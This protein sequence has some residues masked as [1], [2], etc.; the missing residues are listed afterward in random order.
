MSE[1]NLSQD[2][3]SL[4]N[5]TNATNVSFSESL[6]LDINNLNNKNIVII[7]KNLEQKIPDILSFLQNNSN[8]AVNKK[9][10]VKYL[11]NLFLS[12]KINSEVFLRKYSSEK[13]RLNLYQIIIEQYITYTNIN[14]SKN[15]ENDYRKE[16]FNLF[17]IL[18]SQ[19]TLNRESYHY[20]L[21]F[22]LKFINEKN[23]FPKIKKEE[24]EQNEEEFHLTAEHLTRILL[25]LQKFYQ[26]LD[27]SKMSLN[28]F[29][30]YGESES[31]ITIQ[32][33]NSIKDNKKLLTL[34]DNLCILLFIKV[35]PSEYIK[36]AYSNTTFN[37]LELKFNEKCKDKDI[38]I[39]I[40]ME[41]N[42]FTNFIPDKLGKLSEYDTNWLLIK[43]KK[44]KKIKVK[45]YLNGRK[46]Y[47]KKDKDKEKDKD[48][49][50]EDI[51]EIILFKNFIGICY[52]FLIFKT[53]KKEV[54]P[55]FLENEVKRNNLES[56]YE[57]IKDENIKKSCIPKDKTN[58]YN[59]FINEELLFPFIKTEF[60]KDEIEPN[61]LNKFFNDQNP[62]I[63]NNEIKDFL[64]KIIAIYVPSRTVIPS[65]CKNY[66][67]LNT[68][69][70]IIEDSINGLDAEF[71]TKNP[72]LNGLHVYKRMIEDF[73]P[74]G[75]L[76][77]LLPIIEI[78]T[79]Y[80]E[81][82][83]K[84]NLGIFLDMLISIFVPQYQKALL[85]EKNSNFFLYLSYFFEKIP[86]S[87]YDSSLIGIFKSISSFLTTQINENNSFTRISTFIF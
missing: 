7:T 59:G 30:F 45:I 57:I 23:N 10:I 78:M 56:I 77:N 60:I 13:N 81:L 63:N 44:K 21:S 6:L 9:I 18:L 5:S 82:L 86:E 73:G 42:L 19:V 24:E 55:K 17:E 3:L 80:T 46:I 40:D 83:T 36:S 64:E 75:G 34:E 69:Q 51:K 79:R 8:L 11:Q 68:P 58:Y 27:G 28:Y 70:L 12:I 47:Y 1:K 16:L 31:S 2:S 50:K 66:N 67:L 85:K 35:F 76:N 74:I 37:L 71:N 26:F 38:T 15:D 61:L 39:N 54:Y 32:N 33:K 65:S 84:E 49:D 20:I 62:Y 43:F 4:S 72:S 87:F 22:L 29:F 52:N 48:K 14:N 41:N 53:K 25:L